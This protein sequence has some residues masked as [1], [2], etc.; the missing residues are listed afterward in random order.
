MGAG[1]TEM[2]LIK[3][4]MIAAIG[5]LLISGFKGKSSVMDYFELLESRKSLQNSLESM[6]FEIKNLETEIERIRESPD[7]ARRVLR[8]QF[9]VTEEHE[10]IIFFSD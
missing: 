2:T 8:D 3:L 4:M 7:Y 10:N 9:H 6:K 1:H 5:V